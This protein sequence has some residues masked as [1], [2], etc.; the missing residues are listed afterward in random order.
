MKEGNLKKTKGQISLSPVSGR[1]TLEGPLK[2]EVAA[3]MVSARR[4]WLDI[5]LWLK[6][7]ISGDRETFGYSFYDLNAKVNWIIS[8]RNRIYLSHYQGRDGYFMKSKDSLYTD[9]YFFRW[10]N[11]TTVIRWNL[12]ISPQIFMNTSVYRSLY[13]FGER[14]E[15]SGKEN[16]S[17][18]TGSGLKE[19]AVKS[20]IDLSLGRHVIKLGYHYTWQSFQ[21]EMTVFSSDSEKSGN[22]GLKSFFSQSFSGYA[23]DEFSPLR[24]LNCNAG[25]GP[26]YGLFKHEPVHFL[27]GTPDFS[28]VYFESGPGSESVGATADPDSST[29][30]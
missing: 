18:F 2:K 6:Q 14:F 3:F 12:S 30:D 23:E 8:P 11:S 16:S 28:P 24:G 17:Q 21:P 5:P 27:P 13:R 20:D 4:S 19:Y 9:S 15:Y 25:R 1:L 22:S 29:A 10:G 26:D 7:E